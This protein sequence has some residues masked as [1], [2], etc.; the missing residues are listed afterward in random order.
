[1]RPRGLSPGASLVKKSL[2]FVSFR[3]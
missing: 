1:L 3:P 2:H